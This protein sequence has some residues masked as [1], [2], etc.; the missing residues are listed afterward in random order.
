VFV[1]ESRPGRV[2]VLR[3]ANNDGKAEA[4]EVFA[5]GLKQPFGVAFYSAEQRR[6]DARLRRQH[7]Q[8]GALRLQEWRQK[9]ERRTRNHRVR[10]AR[11]RLQPALDPQRRFPTR[12][13]KDVRERRQPEQRERGRGREA[14]AVL[15]YNPD[16]TGY[17]VFASGLRNPVGIAFSRRRNTLWAA[18]N[19]RD[20]LGDDLVPDYVTSVKEGGFYGWPYTYLGANDE[21]RLPDKPELAQKAIVPDVLIGSHAAALGLSF[22]SSSQFP[23]AY[24]NGA[25]VAFARIVEPGRT[26]R[27]QGRARAGRG[28]RQGDGRL[29]GLF[30]RLENKG[31]A[32]LGPPGR[33][34]RGHAGRP[35]RHR[36]RRE[37]SL[38]ACFTEVKKPSPQRA[39][40]NLPLRLP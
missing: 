20:G 25:F 6:T 11:R 1:T 18:V 2:V 21:P 32:G 28:G 36:R 9:G 30:D 37:Q 23:A 15:E 35:A 14:A 4:K 17:R 7:G 27:L 19:E 39:I 22:Y 8:R 5:D 31:G 34:R 33:G 24:R 16:G 26:L 10:P 40:R 13:Q 3:D 29:R 38:G 12:R